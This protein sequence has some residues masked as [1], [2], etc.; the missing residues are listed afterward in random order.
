MRLTAEMQIERLWGSN[1][2][3][4]SNRGVSAKTAQI[5]RLTSRNIV[6]DGWDLMHSYIVLY[7]FVA[8]NELNS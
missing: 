4:R 7:C 3:A 2:E 5:L 8:E 6:D 1:T